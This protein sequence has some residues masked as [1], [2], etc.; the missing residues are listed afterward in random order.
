MREM[1]V[2]YG[3]KCVVL[4]TVFSNAY[5]CPAMAEVTGIKRTNLAANAPM[6]AGAQSS[7]FFPAIRHLDSFRGD[8]RQS[9]GSRNGPKGH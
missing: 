9:L 4:A 2:N 8:A 5:E 6:H 1:T 3:S 7:R